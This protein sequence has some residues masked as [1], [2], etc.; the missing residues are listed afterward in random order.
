[1]P[2]RTVLTLALMLMI[3]LV[4]AASAQVVETTHGDVEGTVEEGN[5]NVFKGIPYAAPP[6]GDRRW[7]PP[8]PPSDW[9]GV[10]AA[11]RFGPRCMQPRLFGDMIFRSAGMSEDCLY[12][13]V[14]TPTTSPDEPLP[15]L[16]YFYGGGL[17]AGDGSE[18][19]YDGASMARE[20]IVVVTL[21]YRLGVFGFLA[22]PELTAESPH[23]A[24]GNYGLL[25]QV[26]A[27]SWVQ[28]NIAA[29][30]G[31]PSQVTIAG[32]SAGS[33]SVSAQMA[34]PLSADLFDRAIG[35]S[36]AI[37]GTLPPVSLGEAEQ[38]GA[39]FAEQIGAAS[40]ADLRRLSSSRLFELAAKPG[41]S[42]FQLAVDGHF[43]PRSP[44]EVYANGEQANV[45]LLVGWNSKESSYQAI[46]QG[47]AP[48]PANYAEAVRNLYGD[49]AERALAVYAADTWEEVITVGTALAGDRFIGY[50]TWTW[51]EMQ[52]QS[53]AP[54]YRYY[55]THPRPPMK[56]GKGNAV[57][58]LAGANPN[59]NQITPPM[60]AA[61]AV[62]IEYALG[63]LDTNP[64]YAWTPADYEVSQLMQGYFA[65]FIKTGNPNGSNASGG[66]PNW[67]AA[68]TAD[69]A[70]VM[71]LNESPEA[72][73][74]QHRDRYEFLD[75]LSSR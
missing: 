61:H 47:E 44:T 68:G 21:N 45:P 25:D 15:V 58:G 46:L 49:Q 48:T 52:R 42:R 29:F 7:Q 41:V 9:D 75:G 19:R 56:P 10:R 2:A 72:Q 30:G 3:G 59:A 20:D 34:S 55:Y 40:L 63:N 39:Q 51:S 37:L 16:V 4:S 11:D 6:V 23:N 50:G 12:V 64:L 43:F 13:N 54:V 1:M 18:P 17:V 36:G 33:M 5:I 24:S 14:W 22:H 32:E 35:E 57:R 27:L 70:M 71:W 69:R 62:E 28:D 66:A 60:G 26:Q 31:D 8:Q 74:E 73:P 67:P 53:G 65:N 38:Q